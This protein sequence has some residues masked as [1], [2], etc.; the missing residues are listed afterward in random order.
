MAA[1]QDTEFL[2]SCF[3]DTG[4]YDL[5]QTGHD[6]RIIIVGRTGTGKSAVLQTLETQYAK[7][8]IRIEPENLALTYVSNS[9][10]LNFFAH[11][12]VNLD[13]FFKL[14]WR[15]VITVEL[16]NHH[17]QDRPNPTSPNLL[18]RLRDLFSSET[19]EDRKRQEAVEYLEKWGKSFWKET[20]FR[21]KEITS[22][23]RESA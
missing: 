21:V 15:H 12:G 11:I 18:S 4:A 1:E 9:T 5:A 22:S 7:K 20:E 10:I 14:L 8:V 3:V 19:K 6:N 23:G 17:F 13:P 16:L 2:P